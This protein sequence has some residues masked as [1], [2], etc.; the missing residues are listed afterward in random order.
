MADNE[1]RVTEPT[2]ESV[3]SVIR[4]VAQFFEPGEADEVADLL[5]LMVPVSANEFT[6]AYSGWAASATTD[7]LLKTAFYLAWETVAAQ[8]A[9]REATGQK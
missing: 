7:D 3:Q 4:S 2:E 1:R 5:P 9:L 6:T 8:R